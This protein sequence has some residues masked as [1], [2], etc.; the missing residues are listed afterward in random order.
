MSELKADI[1][2]VLRS[3]E[4]S[5]AQ[6]HA[7]F[8]TWRT[9]QELT[10]IFTLRWRC[11]SQRHFNENRNIQ[12]KQSNAIGVAVLVCLKSQ[13]LCKKYLNVGSFSIKLTIL[14]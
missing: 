6:F 11:W 4:T 7:V 14:S 10:P 12:G 8:K 1:C 2:A 13:M 9:F 3:N 5:A